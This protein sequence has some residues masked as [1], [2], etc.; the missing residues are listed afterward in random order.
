MRNL[1]II[2]V[3]MTLF[4]CK[5]KQAAIAPTTIYKDSLRIEYRERVE[6]VPDTVFIQIP[7]QEKE[8]TKKDTFSVLENDYAV[9]RV[10]LNQDGSMRHQLST[11]PQLMKVDT[12]KRI[13]YRDSLIYRDKEVRVPYP[14]ER[15][16]SKWEKIKDDWFSYVLGLLI[17][18]LAVNFRKPILKIVRRFI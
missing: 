7:L 5:A 8:V 2:L 3:L 16:L 6:Y 10:W 11:K 4:G 17:I 14:A 13:E 15:K 18:S 9:S 1:I 12:N